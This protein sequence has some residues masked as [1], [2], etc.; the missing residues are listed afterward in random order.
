MA[1]STSFSLYNTRSIPA[2]KIGF[3]YVTEIIYNSVTKNVSLKY[4]N[5]DVK[6]LGTVDPG[7]ARKITNITLNSSNHMIVEFDDASAIDAGQITV[8]YNYSNAIPDGVGVLSA[9]EVA[10]FKPLVSGNAGVTITTNSGV[11]NVSTTLPAVDTSTGF[12]GALA[13]SNYAWFVEQWSSTAAIQGPLSVA[14]TWQTRVLNTQ[15]IN[16]PNFTFNS[17]TG[18]V[19]LPIG[20]YYITAIGKSYRSTVVKLAIR[21]VT[22]N[23]TLLDGVSEVNYSAGAST[24]LTTNVRGYVKVAAPITIKLMQL[25]SAASAN[26]TMG[27]ANGTNAT[28]GQTGT[29]SELN[30]WKVSNTVLP[31]APVPIPDIDPFLLELQQNYYTS[32]SAK[33]TGVSNMMGIT[34]PSGQTVTIG[35]CLGPDK[36]IYLAP[37]N[38]LT[39]VVVIDTVTETASYNTF[40]ISMAAGTSNKYIGACLGA[41]GKVY[42]IPSSAAN[43][44]VIDTVAVSGVANT[45]SLTLS[46]ANKWT[47]GVLARNGKIYCAPANSTDVLVINTLTNTAV[48][49]TFGLT[50]TGTSKWSGAVLGTDGKVYCIPSSATSVLVIDPATDTAILTDFGV[51]MSGTFKWYGGVLGP[52]G[53]IYCMPASAASVLIIDTAGSAEL[54][55]FGLDLSAASKWFGGVLGPNGKIYGVPFNATF[56]LEIDPMTQ[57]AAFVSFGFGSFGG[58]QKWAGGVL[59]DNGKMYFGPCDLQNILQISNPLGAAYSRAVTLS[60]HLNKY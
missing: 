2:D 36:K 54:K 53:K 18:E 3:V 39:S 46:D 17:T 55:N 31:D 24:Q 47:G 44:A 14:N 30:I 60:P 25:S 6:D 5:N 15:R 10:K 1:D 26:S 28:M 29:F 37:Y 41:D 51:S 19:Q 27:E 32:R 42:L 4:S 16:N 43:V 21:D 49:T 9:T 50:L 23:L 38:N 35:G 22:N 8:E 40:G 7:L 12:A 59:A 48:R 11:T 33:L 57:T 58:S 13:Y 34:I 52:D 45:Y 20:T 56:S